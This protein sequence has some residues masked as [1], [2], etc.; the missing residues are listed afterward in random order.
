MQV[1]AADT[2]AAA[3][4]E[5]GLDGS[6][7]Q[8]GRLLLTRVEHPERSGGSG[9][10]QL[11]AGGGTVL[12]VHQAEQVEQGTAGVE[13]G[14]APTAHPLLERRRHKH[15]RIDL[16]PV[17]GPLERLTDQIQIV[18]EDAGAG[19]A[20]NGERDEDITGLAEPPAEPGQLVARVTDHPDRPRDR[21]LRR[22]QPVTERFEQGGP[23][24]RGQLPGTTDQR[25][26]P[27]LPG[28]WRHPSP[29][30]LSGV[31]PQAQRNLWIGVEPGYE[32]MGDVLGVRDRG[33]VLLAR[34]D[35][36]AE[37]GELALVQVGVHELDA[38][39]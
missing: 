23:P 8:R 24:D 20:G 39:R 14:P 2:V 38:G 13:P 35:P 21:L 4:Q 19:A 36:A 37:L 6:G 22:L 1:V 33:F 11:R 26:H 30:E 29:D 28:G 7:R 5:G 32:F 17:V 3:E 31:G 15:E 27:W 25:R 34:D 9:G 10:G 18:V 12:V 16:R